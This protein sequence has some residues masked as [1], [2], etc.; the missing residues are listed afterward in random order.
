MVK[1]GLISDTHKVFSKE[2]QD[3]LKDV[4]TIWHAGDFGDLKTLEEISN[5]KKL[6]GVWG[7]C[8]DWDVRDEVPEY[9]NFSIEGVNVLMMHIGGFPGKYDHRA[10]ELINKFKPQLFVCGHSHILRVMNDKKFNMLTMNPGACG[11]QG[12]HI[13][14]TALRFEISNGEIKNLEL[15]EWQ[16]EIVT[17]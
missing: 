17:I 1:I 12:P 4:D 6:V 11:N 3:F 16:K 5:Y 10:F 15:G 14:R 8:D 9:Q 2:V 13:V 7:N